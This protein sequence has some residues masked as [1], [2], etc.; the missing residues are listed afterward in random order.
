MG[1]LDDC[2][3][4]GMLDMN[5]DRRALTAAEVDDIFVRCSCPPDD[6]GLIHEA[7]EWSKL[8]GF[9]EDGKGR[10]KSGHVIEAGVRMA[11]P[12]ELSILCLCEIDGLGTSAIGRKAGIWAMRMMPLSRVQLD[13]VMIECSDGPGTIWVCREKIPEGLLAASSGGRV[14]VLHDA[15]DIDAL[16]SMVAE[17]MN[18]K[19]GRRHA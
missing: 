14:I 9:R 11:E 12:A 3:G 15:A 8:I 2:V 5:S 4:C 7:F 1:D 6:L 18:R 17:L 19:G 10:K 13:N 16:A